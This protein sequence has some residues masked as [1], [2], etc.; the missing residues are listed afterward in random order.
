MLSLPG[1][2]TV[3]IGCSSPAEVDDNARIARAFRP[4]DESVMRA[5]EAH[6]CPHA[7]F[8]TSYKRTM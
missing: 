3:I 7:D 6:T 2:S 4:F 5:I 8:F 1:V